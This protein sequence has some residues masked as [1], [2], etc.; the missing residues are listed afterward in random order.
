MARQNSA[1]ERQAAHFPAFDAAAPAE[2]GS[3]L[4]PFQSLVKRLSE[5]YGPSGSEEGVRE[6]VRQEI[7]GFVDQ[8]RV[9]A[10]GNLTAQRRGTGSHRQKIMLSAHLD[11]IGVMVT[12]IDSRGFARF[13]TLGP[14]KPLTLLG[15][16]VQFANGTLGVIGREEKNASRNELDMDSLF[17]DLGVSAVEPPAVRVGDSAG[18]VREFFDTSD[19]MVGKALNDRV[20][21]AI[22]IETLRQLK[23]S[24]YD[25][26]FVFTIQQKIGGRGAGAAAFSLQPDVAFVIDAAAASDIPGAQANGITLGKGPAIKFQ[27]EGALT[28]SSARQMLL[29]AAREARVPYQL[30]VTPRAGGDSL[31]IQAAREGVPTAALAVPMRYLNT[32]SEMVRHDDIQDAIKLLGNLLSNA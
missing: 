28:T 16:P 7:K 20:G 5:A 27:D 32:P 24:P 18:F 17:I 12:F 22:L 21:C 9:D 25:L 30:D 23:K 4:A 26:S 14:V 6:M 10:L 19:C 3:A 1:R 2:P 13:G 11:E 29:N 15:A 8:V 31:P